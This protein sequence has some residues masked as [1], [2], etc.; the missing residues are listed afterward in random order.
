M[1]GRRHFISVVLLCTFV[2]FGLSLIRTRVVGC[3]VAIF[4]NKQKQNYEQSV[5]SL[6]ASSLVRKP[7][8][9]GYKVQY[10]R[11]E[12]G[13]AGAACEGVIAARVEY[14]EEENTTVLLAD[15]ANH[16]ADADESRKGRR[17]SKQK[18]NRAKKTHHDV[19]REKKHK[20]ALN[21]KKK[22][23]KNAGQQRSSVAAARGPHKRKRV[24]K[25]QRFAR[26]RA[27]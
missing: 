2:I 12:A 16:E 21:K 9:P 14:S 27:Q 24:R 5:A 7:H 18:S 8:I 6:A 25:G 11:R 10:F 23:E 15:A 13:M 1:D 3:N 22:E 19:I 4:F 26:P 17:R 20:K